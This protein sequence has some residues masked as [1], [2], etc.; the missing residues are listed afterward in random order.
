MRVNIGYCLTLGMDV[1]QIKVAAQ[2]FMAEFFDTL[3]PESEYMATIRSVVDRDKR[4]H[5]ERYEAKDKNGWN[6]FPALTNECNELLLQLSQRKKLD[7]G[8]VKCGMNRENV[9]AI[10][11]NGDVLSCHDFATRDKYVGHISAMGKVDISKHFKSCGEREKCRKCLLLSMC[12][13]ACPQIEGL[14]HSRVRTSSTITSLFF[15]RSGGC[16]LV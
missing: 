14:E 1:E 13:G 12:R 11:L 4:R 5:P 16:C 6:K 3:L 2:Q 15:R 8:T 9:C 7:L 10:N